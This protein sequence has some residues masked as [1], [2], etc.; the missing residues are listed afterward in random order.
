VSYLELRH[1]GATET[2]DVKP[3]PWDIDRAL[4]PEELKAEKWETRWSRMEKA[5]LAIGLIA[6]LM[7]LVMTW[8]A[9]RPGGE[10]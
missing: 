5:S 4:T 2:P 9:F 7:G 10:E 6:G 8:R 3:L 1:L